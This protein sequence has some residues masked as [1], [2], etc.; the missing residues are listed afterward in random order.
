MQDKAS[1]EVA[2][3]RLEAAGLE[4]VLPAALELLSFFIELSHDRSAS[5]LGRP[6]MHALLS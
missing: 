3:L 5:S 4:A 2:S 6:D 1:E